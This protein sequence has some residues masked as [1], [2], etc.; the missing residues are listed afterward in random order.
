M[1]KPVISFQSLT[2]CFLGPSFPSPKMMVPSEA[3]ESIEIQPCEQVLKEEEVPPAVEVTPSQLPGE[4]P[5]ALQGCVWQPPGRLRTHPGESLV[6][7]NLGHTG[8]A[9]GNQLW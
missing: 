2:H 1:E 4:R 6:Q 8:T 7:G 9:T 3:H 5:P